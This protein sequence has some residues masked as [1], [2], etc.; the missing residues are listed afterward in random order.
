MIRG[1][2]EFRGCSKSGLHRKTSYSIN[3]D[4][5]HAVTSQFLI[6]REEFYVL[7]NLDNNFALSWVYM[8]MYSR[9]YV[10]FLEIRTMYDFTISFFTRGILYH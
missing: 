3:P 8:Y 9:P 5:F 6:L 1:Q 7:F 2:Y 10:K 4:L